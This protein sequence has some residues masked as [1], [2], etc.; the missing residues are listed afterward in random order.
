MEASKEEGLK[1][2]LIPAKK[3]EERCIQ[4]RIP[5]ISTR[6]I[7]GWTNLLDKIL[8]DYILIV[9][10]SGI[11]I[12]VKGGAI[13]K[14]SILNFKGNYFVIFENSNESASE[15]LIFT[16][17]VLKDLIF[18]KPDKYFDAM[19]LSGEPGILYSRLIQLKDQ[20]I[21]ISDFF[22]KLNTTEL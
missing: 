4:N 6:E 1:I 16:P 18:E 21:T 17:K 11:F 2:G 15:G 9:H 13:S 5:Y 19:A 12:D 14:E 20:A 7:K 10:T 22:K 8:G 3:L